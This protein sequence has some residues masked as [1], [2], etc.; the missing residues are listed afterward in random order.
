MQVKPAGLPET[1]GIDP[2]GPLIEAIDGYFDWRPLAGPFAS[3]C[4]LCTAL[5]RHLLYSTREY[6]LKFV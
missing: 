3:C 4:V 5:D 2:L 6:D 1:S